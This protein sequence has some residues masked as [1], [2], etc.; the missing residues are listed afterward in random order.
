[1]TLQTDHLRTTLRA[2][3]AS[4]ELYQRALAEGEATHQEIFRLAIVK[5]F[6][7]TQEVCFKLLRRRLRDFGHVGRGLD[8][9]PVKELLRLGARHGLLTVDEVER[10]F[11]Y[12]DN[13]NDTAHDYG[14]GFAH[15]TLALMPAFVRDVRAM[16]ARL[17]GAEGQTP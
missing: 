6:E 11:G 10:W 12:R 9:T 3:E 2:L 15:E 5:G 14:E 7:L 1:M 16:E 8:A 13:R 17:A 4:V